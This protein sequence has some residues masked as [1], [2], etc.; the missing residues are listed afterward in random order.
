MMTEHIRMQCLI[1]FFLHHTKSESK[2][3]FFGGEGRGS[4]ANLLIGVLPGPA[5][6][7]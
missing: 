4:A 3:T 1:R 7:Q 5:Q 6:K 2:G